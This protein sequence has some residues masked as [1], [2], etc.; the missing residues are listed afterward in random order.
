MKCNSWS[1]GAFRKGARLGPQGTRRPFAKSATFFPRRPS[2]STYEGGMGDGGRW[3]GDGEGGYGC[4]TTEAEG[5]TF[6]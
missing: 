2:S 3:G 1:E 6:V 5:M 4:A